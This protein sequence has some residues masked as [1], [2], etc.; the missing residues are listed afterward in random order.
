MVNSSLNRQP[1]ADAIR[2]SRNGLSLLEV[3]LSIALLGM[4]MVIINQLIGIGYRSA[5]EVRIYT[6]ASI[7][8]DS[9]MAEVASGVLELEQVSGVSI[10]TDPDWA[11]SVSIEE[12][13]QI[14][15]LSVTVTVEQTNIA[16]PVSLSVVRFMPDPDYDPYAIEDN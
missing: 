12:S 5:S 8:V 1:G 16:N 15:L 9:K 2:P 6:D 4:A 13:D 3:I 7:L 14:G 11:Y 10:D